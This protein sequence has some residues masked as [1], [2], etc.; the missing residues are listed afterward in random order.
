MSRDFALFNLAIDSTLR[1]YDLL[2][3][4]VGDIAHANHVNSRAV[5]VQAA[6]VHA[7]DNA[8]GRQIAE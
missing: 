8:V 5:V 6:A 3:L 2:C 1:T 4:R 7:N